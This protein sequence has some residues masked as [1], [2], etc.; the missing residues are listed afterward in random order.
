MKT[1]IQRRIGR[2]KILQSGVALGLFDIE[3]SKYGEGPKSIM[4]V[5][6]PLP[7]I[8]K[9]GVAFFSFLW[10]GGDLLKPYT[11][12]SSLGTAPDLFTCDKYRVSNLGTM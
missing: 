9:K 6:P 5:L 7:S 11:F 10:N 1:I 8:P 12:M 3:P 2:M 4:T